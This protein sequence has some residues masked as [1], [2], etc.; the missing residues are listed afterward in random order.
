MTTEKPHHPTHSNGQNQS[1][2]EKQTM[3]KLTNYYSQESIDTVWRGFLALTLALTVMYV[4]MEAMAANT[5][6]AIERLFCNVV[7][8]LTGPTGKAIAT[9]AIIVVG[10]GALMGKVSWGMALIVA[11]GVALVFGAAS[12]VNAI[13]GADA[14]ACTTGSVMDL[15]AGG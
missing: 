3:L 1:I 12:I 8:M 14:G 6:N 2:K 11:L 10:L 13:A 4:P 9:I 7:S 5:P 15:G